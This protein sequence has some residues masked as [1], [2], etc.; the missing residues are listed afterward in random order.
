MDLS[1]KIKKCKTCKN[2]KWNESRGILCGLTNLKPT[3]EEDCESYI[4]D[5]VAIAKTKQSLLDKIA[6]SGNHTRKKFSEMMNEENNAMNRRSRASENILLFSAIT[7]VILTIIFI[8][9]SLFATIINFDFD[10]RMIL[11]WLALILGALVT[12]ASIVV[13]INISYRLTEIHQILKKK[14]EKNN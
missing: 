10:W 12:Y 6:I 8:V 13:L 14:E 4:A 1:E 7:I 5:E 2:H 9:I 11:V 3:F